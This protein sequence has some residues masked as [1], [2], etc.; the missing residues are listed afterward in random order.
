MFDGSGT[1]VDTSRLSMAHDLP[2][3][4]MPI[5]HSDLMAI[6]IPSDADRRL[7]EAMLGCSYLAEVI[8]IRQSFSSWAPHGPSCGRSEATPAATA[9]KGA[10]GKGAQLLFLASAHSNSERDF[11]RSVSALGS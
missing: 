2:I 11:Q 7:S 6:A 10:R 9:G 8:G 5:T 4:T 3:P 1:P